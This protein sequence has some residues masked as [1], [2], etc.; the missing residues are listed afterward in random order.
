MDISKQ[1]KAKTDTLAYIE[2]RLDCACDD[3]NQEVAQ[4]SLYGNLPELKQNCE[5]WARQ[6]VIVKA[7]LDLYIKKSSQNVLRFGLE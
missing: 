7:E 6:K 1:I 5:H 3:Y 4:P 2:R